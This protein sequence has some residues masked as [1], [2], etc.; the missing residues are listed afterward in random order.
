VQ[1]TV[2]S[3][4]LTVSIK[5]GTSSGQ[6]QGI[7]TIYNC[8]GVSM[9]STSY[10]SSGSTSI[11][12]SSGQTAPQISN[13][14]QQNAPSPDNIQQENQ[15][16]QNLKQEMENQQQNY[17]NMK[18]ELGNRIENNG[19]FKQMKNELEK[20]GYNL[21][22]K[23]IRPS[24][25]TSGEFNYSFN[26]NN[27]TA[28]ISGKMDNG[29]MVTINK[30]SSEDIKRLQQLIESNATFRQM[31]SSLIDKGYNLSDKKID[32]KSNIS[33]FDY[34]FNDSQGRD[35]SIT[36]NITNAG[37]IKDISLNEPKEP[38][39]YW[40]LAFLI[41]P[42]LGI[43][44]YK[45]YRDN[46]RTPS[47]APVVAPQPHVDPKKEALNRL[48]KAIEMFNNGMQREA[49]VEVSNAVRTY[50]KGKM[51]IKELT[52]E[53]MLKIIKESKDETYTGYVKQCFTQ[54]DLVKFAKYE[55]NPEDFNKAVE[56][57]KNVIV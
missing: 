43:Y 19:E 8:N 21:T 38:L 23:E 2:K 35:A 9:R 12:I 17:Q 20:Q 50:F 54:C 7:T 1:E 44:L 57:A 34:R 55:P 11:S 48:E 4:P 5:Q 22:D 13:P 42:L 49:Y 18:N 16:M 36:G 51:G 39:P 37:E 26:K 27:E 29:S 41:L 31:Q 6:Q 14:N 28:S 56:Y 24:T 52:S 46:G 45:R 25:N 3:E 32:L 47:V 30:Q 10:S 40:M 15:D 33:S 53:E